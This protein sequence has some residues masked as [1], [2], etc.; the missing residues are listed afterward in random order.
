MAIPDDNIT[1]SKSFKFKSRFLYNTNN[2]GTTVQ[3]AVSFIKIPG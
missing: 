2:A 1:N 3:M